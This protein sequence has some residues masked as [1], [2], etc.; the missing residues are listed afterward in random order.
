VES[1]AMDIYAL[2]GSLIYS[3]TIQPLKKSISLSWDVINANIASGIYLYTTK[4]ELDGKT[5]VKIG[6]FAVLY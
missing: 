1:F 5:T 3:Q 6:K 4:I 2:D